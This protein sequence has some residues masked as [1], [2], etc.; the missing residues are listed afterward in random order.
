MQQTTTFSLS[1]HV[2]LENEK[3][4][5]EAFTIRAQDKPTPFA[6]GPA[7]YLDHVT[8]QA[9]DREFQYGRPM[10]K[11]NLIY[12][13]GNCECGS[14]PIVFAQN[15]FGDWRKM[16]E[17]LTSAAS[18]HASSFAITLPGSAQQ[19]MISENR[20]ETTFLLSLVLTGVSNRGERRFLIQPVRD[21]V[22]KVSYTDPLVIDL[23]ELHATNPDLVS[24]QLDGLGY[25]HSETSNIC[26]Y[27]L[28]LPR[29]LFE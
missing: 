11:N 6:F 15:R 29:I 4:M 2:T 16:G 18:P 9:G 20:G 21:G 1:R 22:R 5:P 3:S 14:C 26:P 12:G 24:L 10:A 17:V 13:N 19:L 23:R 7:I 25:Y 28:P 27:V 8:W